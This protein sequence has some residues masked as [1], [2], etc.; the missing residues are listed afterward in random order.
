MDNFEMVLLRL[1]AGLKQWQLAQLLGISQTYLCELERGKRAI[2]EEMANRIKKAVSGE[3]VE[4]KSR[5]TM[6]EMPNRRKVM[7]NVHTSRHS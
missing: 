2:T 3:P 5:I 4:W 1:R 7:R 6:T